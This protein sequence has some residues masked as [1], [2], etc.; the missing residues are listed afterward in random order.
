MS[1]TTTDL[2]IAVKPNLLADTNNQSQ[3]SLSNQ[4]HN[5]VYMVLVWVSEYRDYF[6]YL[7]LISFL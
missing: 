3:I 1:L 7:V 4:F 2:L 6:T 5:P